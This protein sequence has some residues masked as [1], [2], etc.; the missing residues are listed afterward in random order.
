[1]PFGPVDIY[2]VTR[3]E[4]VGHVLLDNWRNYPKGDA[5]WRPL[6]RLLGQG[7]VTSDGDLWVKNRRL[8]QPLFAPKHLAA[9]SATMVSVLERSLDALSRRIKP[10]APLNI[11][12][13]LAVITQNVVLET[14]FGASIERGEAERLTTALIQSFRQMNLRMFL[15]FLPD[16]LPLPG[17]GAIKRA[18]L[19]FDEAMFRLVRER[20]STGERRKDLLSLLLDARD[21]ETG[22]P[23]SDRQIRDELVTLFIAGNETTAL[24]MTWLLYL[25]DK[26]PEAEAKVRAEAAEVLGRRLPTYEDLPQLKYSKMVVQETLRLY[27]PSWMIPRVAVAEDEV[28]GYRIPAGATVIVSQY[29]MHRDP[30][31][32]DRPEAFDPERFR[33]EVAS[34]RPRY[35]YMPFGG[36]P[37]LCIGDQFAIMETQLLLAM[38]V[39]RFRARLAPG[40]RVEAKAMATLRPRNGMPMYV[41]R[42]G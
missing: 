3:P 38:F 8:L 21:P 31:Q 10:G 15:F 27:P 11:E 6:R 33:P 22:E 23:M 1:M 16:H 42:I 7:L 41:D 17:E 20:R 2:L 36:G 5:M 28:D 25:L 35:T 39:Q 30:T 40:A 29:L 4:H 24:T 12:N 32:W 13:E 14:V 18:V 34:T 37:R 26:N 9:L 19:T